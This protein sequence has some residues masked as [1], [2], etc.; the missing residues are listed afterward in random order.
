VFLLVYLE[1]KS[2]RDIIFFFQ[3]TVALQISYFHLNIARNMSN[4][5]SKRVRKQ[6]HWLFIGFEI[7]EHVTEFWP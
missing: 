1:Y 2:E 4:M 7:C 3:A 6:I 5:H